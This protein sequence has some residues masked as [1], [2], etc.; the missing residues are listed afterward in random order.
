[1]Y[2]VL[3]H[4]ISCVA[5]FLYSVGKKG[6]FNLVWK[7]LDLWVPISG[8]AEICS[9]QTLLQTYVVEEAKSLQEIYYMEYLSPND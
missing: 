4:G 8:A 2:F 6:E 3:W 1:M 7:L 9:L 5:G